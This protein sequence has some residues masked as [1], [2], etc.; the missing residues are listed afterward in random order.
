MKQYTT[1]HDFEKSIDMMVR[2]YKDTNE[3]CQGVYGVRR[4]GLPI[5]VALSH[6]LD[7]PMYPDARYGDI[8]KK[9]LI[10]DDI[11]D[12]GKTLEF[13]QKMDR[14]K[15]IYTMHYHRQSSIVPDFWTIEK[16]DKWIVYP[17][18][19]SMLNYDWFNKVML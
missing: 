15:V 12:T 4:G 16:K 6:R 13:Y 2:H 14:P 7:I 10:V 11:A 19:T 18:E 3:N 8:D 9:I 1:W 17:W 5:A